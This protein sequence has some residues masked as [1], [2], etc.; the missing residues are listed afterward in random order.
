MMFNT[1]KLPY[2]C[3]SIVTCGQLH[4]QFW[5]LNQIGT[6]N[7]DNILGIDCQGAAGQVPPA[8][9]WSYGTLIIGVPF[10]MKFK[11]DQVPKGLLKQINSKIKKYDHKTQMHP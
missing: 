5:L 4:T 3:G 2:V 9:L 6:Q 11:F 8:V 1:L 10:K 7:V